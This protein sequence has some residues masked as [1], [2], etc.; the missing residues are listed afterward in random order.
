MFAVE[1]FFYSNKKCSSDITK[2][3]ALVRTVSLIVRR[4]LGTKGINGPVEK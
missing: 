1:L 2:N 3:E 4:I